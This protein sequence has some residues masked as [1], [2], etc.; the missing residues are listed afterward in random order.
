MRSEMTYARMPEGIDPIELNL[1]NADLRVFTSEELMAFA[2]ATYELRIDQLKQTTNWRELCI[3]L[4]VQL[5]HCDQQMRSAADE[6]GYPIWCQRSTV[7]DVLTEAKA[8]FAAD[9][10]VQKDGTA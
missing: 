8:A 2:D 9:I 1:S 4:Y 6:D 3:R 10:A 5:F 7:L